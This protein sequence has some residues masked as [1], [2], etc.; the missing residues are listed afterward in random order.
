MNRFGLAAILTVSVVLLATSSTLAGPTISVDSAYFLTAI[1]TE[2]LVVHTFILKNVGDESLV[3]SDVVPS[4]SCTTPVL[5][6]QELEPGETAELVATV[7]TTG[8]AG[9][10]TREIFVFSNDFEMPALIL[11]I[12]VDA[13]V[14]A[15][16]NELSQETL[17]QA[18]YVLVDVRTQEEFDA[19]H[20]WGAVHI[21]LSELQTNLDAWTPYLPHDVPLV[22]YCK[23][24]IRSAIGAQ[25]LLD[26]GFANVFDLPGGTDA[27]V[28]TYGDRFLFDEILAEEDS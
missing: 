28:E 3:I 16:P 10:V 11:T 7:D 26:A 20:L 12:D 24:G 21:P 6:D 1:Q 14:R 4:C 25:I 22:V 27:W 23:A 17:L 8:F 5:S 2:S 18:F 13:P 19:G 15:T 9:L